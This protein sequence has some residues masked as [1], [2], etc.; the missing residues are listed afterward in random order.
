MFEKDARELQEELESKLGRMEYRN[1]QPFPE[2]NDKINKLIELMAVNYGNWQKTEFH[3][4]KK[5]LMTVN[6]TW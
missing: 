6:L 1:L 3:A 5:E 4:V 2:Q